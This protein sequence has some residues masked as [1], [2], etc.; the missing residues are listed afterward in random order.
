MFGPFRKEKPLQGFMGLG[1]GAAAISKSSSAGFTPAPGIDAS[2]GYVNQWQS[3]PGTCYRSHIFTSPGTFTVTAASTDPT[4]PS[5]CQYFVCGGGGGGGQ[6][7]PGP[8][9][10]NGGGGG[11]AGGCRTNFPGHPKASPA[12][13]T[14]AAGTYTVTVGRGGNQRDGSDPTGQ[15]TGGDSEF[16]PDPVS[17]PNTAFIR[18]SGGGGGGY[19]WDSPTTPATGVDGGSGGGGGAK[20][21]PGTVAGG[22]ALTDPNHPASQGSAG[23][24]G[25]HNPGVSI[26]FGGGGGWKEDGRDIG[27]GSE[28]GKGGQGLEMPD[29]MWGPIGPMNFG[30]QGNPTQPASCFAGG[31]GGGGGANAGGRGGDGP[32]SSGDGTTAGYAGAGSGSSGPSAN[33]AII[34]SGTPGTGGGGGGGGHPSNMAGKGGD[35][36]IMIRYQIGSPTSTAKATGGVISYTPTHTIHA[37]TGTGTFVA[38]GPF[39]ETLEYVIVGGGGAGGY[40]NG[41]GGGAGAYKT[42]TTPISGPST[43]T[44]TVGAGGW[45][46]YQG[47]PSN[48]NPE[49]YGSQSAFGPIQVGGGGVGSSESTAGGDYPG[50]AP[51]G[52]SGGGAGRGYPGGKLG[53][54]GG[55]LGNNG[56]KSAGYPGTDHSATAGGGGSGAV[57]Q[58][59]STSTP[60]GGFGGQGTQ[61]PST[62]RAGNA[63]F[64][65]PGPGGAT[66]YV[67]GGGGGA[68]GH[69]TAGS[70]DQGFGGSYDGSSEIPGGPYAG[71]GNGNYRTSSP[72]P[73]VTPGGANTGGGG[74]GGTDTPTGHGA[75]GLKSGGNG[76]SGLI[77]VAYP[78]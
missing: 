75:G 13:Y 1:G 73:Q 16:Y 37:F 46:A 61:I 39:S 57:G 32:P 67:C 11:G 41:G 71:G 54:S 43:T 15:A 23:G 40:H 5:D 50:P 68:S 55:A 27:S 78:S 6:G 3:P 26:G 60:Q 30:A 66:G 77:L 28:G 18:G 74:G 69:P 52:G 70:S 72:N 24:Y 25:H 2:G 22:S 47:P 42:G 19:A 49:G 53:G 8:T 51:E 33:S 62:F 12:T 31:G 34:A 44:V 17:Y 9:T 36:I 7:G 4:V 64:G 35:G 10:T 56:G 14:L 48:L 58:D 45:G 63:V 29:D 21:G 38:P 20:S 59:A 76:G 65:A